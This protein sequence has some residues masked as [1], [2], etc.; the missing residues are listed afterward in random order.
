[1]RP[2]TK[3]CRTGTGPAIRRMSS[4]KPS[5]LAPGCRR[6][7]GAPDR[8]AA[9]AAARC[10]R[11]RPRSR[12]APMEPAERQ[13]AREPAGDRHVG[14]P[15]LAD[16]AMVGLGVMGQNLALNLSDQGHSVAVYDREPHVVHD[17]L[18]GPG[19]GRD[20][21]GFSDLAALAARSEERRVGEG[22]L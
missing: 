1:R 15:S 17:F 2:P 13:P 5:T 14:P 21:K 6:V 19:A 18:A 16:V 20:V 11:Q 9:P 8:R 3:L 10:S 22:G 12:L 7:S 4:A